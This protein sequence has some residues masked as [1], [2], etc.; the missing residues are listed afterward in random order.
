MAVRF[1]PLDGGELWKLSRVVGRREIG[2]LVFGLFAEVVPIHQEKD[3]L[4][5]GEF[6]EAI[7]D[8]DAAKVLPEPVAIWTSARGSASAKDSS[9]LRI[10]LV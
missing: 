9:R 7:G 5:V 2:E 3:A 1:E 8:V 6:Q 10:A 4:G